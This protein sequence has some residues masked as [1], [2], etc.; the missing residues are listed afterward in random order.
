MWALFV[1]IVV[2]LG[3]EVMIYRAS[4]ADAR[5]PTAPQPITY[6]DARGALAQ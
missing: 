2:Y 3:R 1:A 6:A 5:R 4:Q